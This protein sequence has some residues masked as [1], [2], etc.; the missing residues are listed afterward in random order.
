MCLH[1]YT[2]IYT[3]QHKHVHICI[4][5]YILIMYIYIHICT[6]I[7]KCICFYI[8][9][10]V[11]ICICKYMYIWRRRSRAAASRSGWQQLPAA[12]GRLAAVGGWP[13]VAMMAGRPE[14]MLPQ[15]ARYPCHRSRL[16]SQFAEVYYM[17]NH[18]NLVCGARAIILGSSA[19]IVGSGSVSNASSCR[20]T[21]IAAINSF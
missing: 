15:A 19:C 12:G 9:G 17:F 6:Y 7:H 11:Y 1:I 16:Q 21:R 2:Y 4:Y 10:C 8:F 20:M 13:T 14:W 3:Y 5:I 18:G